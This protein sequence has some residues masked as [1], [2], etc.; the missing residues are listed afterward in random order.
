MHEALE[1]KGKVYW[2]T[3]LSG[4][5]KT[6]IGTLFF[7]HLRSQKDNVVYLDGDVLREVFGGNHG[8][9]I[10]ERQLLAMRYSRLCNMLANQGADVVC[11]TI[12]MFHDVRSWNRENIS[13]Y[14]EV[15]VK[16]PIEVLIERDQKK[17]YSRSLRGEIKNVMGVDVDIEEPGSPDVTILNDGKKAPEIIIQDLLKKLKRK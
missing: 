7:K 5:G 8:H 3:G 1:D 13:N 11:A 2:F 17:L 4:A 12:S 10:E 15:Y 9:A 6:T 14:V 16:V